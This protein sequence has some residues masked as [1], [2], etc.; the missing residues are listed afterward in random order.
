MRT[1]LSMRRRSDRQWVTVEIDERGFGV[2]DIVPYK[3]RYLLLQYTAVWEE[4]FGWRYDVGLLDLDKV[5]RWR[6]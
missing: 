6:E 2:N 5:A 4:P 1:Q 3:D